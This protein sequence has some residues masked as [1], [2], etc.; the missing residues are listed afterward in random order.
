M[1]FVKT[2]D[3][4]AGM[5]LAKPIYNKNGV[6]LYERN[7][8]LTAPG[9]ASAKNFGLIGVYVLEPAEPALPLSDEDLEFE[10]LQTIYIFHLR[11]IID[12]ISEHRK[13]DKLPEFLEDIISHYGSLDHRVNFNPNLRSSDDFMYKHAIST[14]ILTAM[15]GSRLKL[16]SEKMHILITA[17]LLYDC[18][19]KNVPRGILEK[20]V[21]LSAADQDILQ[22][23]LE[24]G[25]MPLA[26]YRN[27]FPYFSRALA[28]MQTYVYEDHMEK[29]SA[30]PDQELQEMAAIIRVADHFDQM[31]AMNIGYEP[32]SE[33]AAM[34]YFSQHPKK[35]LPIL[36]STLAECIHI[37]P[38]AANVDLSTGDKGIVLV[39]NSQDYMRPVVLRLKDNQIYDLSDKDTFSKLQVV[40]IMKT[41]DN[42]VVM[43]KE[44]L[45]QF[46]PDEKLI[47]LTQEFRRKLAKAKS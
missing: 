7:S 3:L 20:G 21:Q 33:I 10:K 19:Y 34:K 9:I 42:R 32:K 2:D 13:L 29:L 37:V 1:K 30:T 31:T 6:L 35:Y 22:L 8:A 16:S 47:K 4:K 43:D 26:M 39:E 23:S 12:N 41:M 46:V 38:H 45:K 17:A 25:L 44:T 40:D 24:K 27:D 11:E 14:A 36:V 18:G 5:R 15:M 28:L